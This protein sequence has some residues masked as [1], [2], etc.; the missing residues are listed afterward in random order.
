VNRPRPQ[1]SQQQPDRRSTGRRRQPHCGHRHFSAERLNVSRS[2]TSDV[3][4][5]MP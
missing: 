2:V 5:P 4:S 1:G 3:A